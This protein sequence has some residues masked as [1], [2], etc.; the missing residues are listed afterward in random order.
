MD[1]RYCSE[2]IGNDGALLAIRASGT[3]RSEIPSYMTM[4]CH[5]INWVLVLR[6]RVSH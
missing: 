3:G 1:S 4:N 6:R 2:V 5:L